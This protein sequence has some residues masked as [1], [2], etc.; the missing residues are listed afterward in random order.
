VA[1]L[2]ASETQSRER[3]EHF[4]RRSPSRMIWSIGVATRRSGL[5]RVAGRLIAR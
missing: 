5:L 4:P 1:R 2:V 3:G